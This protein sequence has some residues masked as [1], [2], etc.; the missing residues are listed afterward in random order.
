ML[1]ELPEK[2]LV[3]AMRCFQCG[4]CR[5]SCPVFN[6]KGVGSWNARG[7]LLLTVAEARGQIG[8]EESVREDFIDRIFS[9]T[10]CKSC[11]ESCPPKVRVSDIIM[12][13]REVLTSKE[14]TP[15]PLLKLHKLIEETGNILG[16]TIP[17]IKAIEEL[18]TL[19]SSEGIL[20]YPGCTA[21][22]N[23]PEISNAAI[24]TLKLLKEPIAA[25]K[26]ENTCCGLFL[27]TVGLK[28]V[29][30]KHKEKIAEKFEKYDTVITPCPMCMNMIKD[31]YKIGA[32]HT[33]L[34][35]KEMIDSEK[36][37]L[38]KEVK[39][40]A[41]YMDPCHLGRYAKIYEEPRS[42]LSQ[43][44]GLKLVE[45]E[46]NKEDSNCCG[47][48]IRITHNS[49]KD[50]LTEIIL[51]EAEQNEIEMIITA[52]PTCFHSLSTL[53]VIYDIFPVDINQLVAYS[54]ELTKN[55]SRFLQ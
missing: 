10:L 7:R 51:K 52:C 1:K 15:Q 41:A 5:A 33:T 14:E 49:I 32:Q 48:P 19:E 47:G 35:L 31:E 27:D 18:K 40:T 44:P 26:N 16:S 24:K 37:K 6:V 12:S 23:Y 21:T 8:R 53:C 25:I 28:D 46:H 55:F 9:C 54:A 50:A 3:E 17:P 20:F 34:T 13:I 43:I 45:L 22:H 2:E 4:Y 29:F 39:M 42:I 38:K 36:I 30:K 11:E